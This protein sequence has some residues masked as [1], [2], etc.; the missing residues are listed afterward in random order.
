[1]AATIPRTLETHDVAVGVGSSASLTTVR[2]LV[3]VY[4]EVSPAIGDT[5]DLSAVVP[6]VAGILGMSY[7]NS[8]TGN[9]A[10]IASQASW[11][12][13]TVTWKTADLQHAKF[14]G[15]YT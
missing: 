4:I 10:T 14:T 11:S 2:R 1:M 7:N 13:T 6:N 9:I 5:T 3:E 8:A 12:G 15:Y